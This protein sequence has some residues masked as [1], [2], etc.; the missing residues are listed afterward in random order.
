MSANDYG[1][2]FLG[3]EG[4]SSEYNVFRFIVQQM[5]ARVRTAIPVQVVA[6]SNAG[7]VAP[8][9]Y[10]TVEPLVCMLDGAGNR[11]PHVPVYGLLYFRLQGGLNAVICDPQP[12]DIGTAVIC[13]RDMS[14]VK[15]NASALQAGTPG[16][17]NTVNPGSLSKFNLTDGIYYGGNLNAAPTS[18]LQFDAEGNVNIVVP[19]SRTITVNGGTV[20]VHGS[21]IYEWDVQ[22]Y[23]Q[24]ITWTGSNNFTIDNYTEGTNVT[25]N[26]HNYDPPGPP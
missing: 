11:V 13:D 22:G 6:C 18:Y 21:S 4:W 9:G 2:G 5:L 24:K 26:N 19:A 25:T 20:K 7:G 16:P 8:F 14:L 17:G 3:P 12:G 1:A 23:G 10:V 15:S